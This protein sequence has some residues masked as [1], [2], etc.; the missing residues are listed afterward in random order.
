MQNRRKKFGENHTYSCEWYVLEAE[1][2]T[3]AQISLIITFI[4]HELLPNSGQNNSDNQKWVKWTSYM[5]FIFNLFNKFEFLVDF[6]MEF[7]GRIFS[8]ALG[9]R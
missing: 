8:E 7:P 1:I 3:V 6:S 2:T 5:R 4:C 9:M